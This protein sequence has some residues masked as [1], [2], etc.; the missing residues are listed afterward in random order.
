M[1]AEILELLAV[2]VVAI[3]V[4]GVIPVLIIAKIG[5]WILKD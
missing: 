3:L 4:F 1:I 5:E 2:A